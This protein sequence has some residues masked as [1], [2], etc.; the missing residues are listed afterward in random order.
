MPGFN[1]V[2]RP[3][4]PPISW[5]KGAGQELGRTVTGPR[6]LA[7]VAGNDDFG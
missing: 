5:R 3:A 2:S 6:L 7:T 4:S 1:P